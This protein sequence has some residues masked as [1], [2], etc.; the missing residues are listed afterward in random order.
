M[1][2]LQMFLKLLPLLAIL[3]TRAYINKIP[4]NIDGSY[5]LFN[6][7]WACPIVKEPGSDGNVNRVTLKV[8]HCWDSSY[9][10]M[11]C[12]GYIEPKYI[13]LEKNGKPKITVDAN[14]YYFNT[15]KK[16]V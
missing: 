10:A 4:G 8:I 6:N 2:S 11:K 13:T 3:Q 16:Y 15:V 1:D 14:R 7:T 5:R 12:S 9:R